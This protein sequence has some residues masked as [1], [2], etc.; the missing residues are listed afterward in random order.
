MQERRIRRSSYGGARP[1]RDFPLLVDSYLN[2]S[3]MLDE[4]ITQRIGLNEINDGFSAM[5]SG[6]S[7]RSVIVFN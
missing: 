1:A 7:I 5:R 4:V 3:L 6:A 2:G